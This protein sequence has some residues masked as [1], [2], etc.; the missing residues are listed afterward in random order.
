MPQ[1][2]DVFCWNAKNSARGF[3]FGFADTRQTLRSH[4]LIVAA[5]I[6]VSV[7]DHDDLVLIFCQKRHGS[8][9]GKSVIVR[10][11]CK[12]QDGLVGIVLEPV[13]GA[14]IQR[15]EE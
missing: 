14:S 1:P 6:I 15:Q 13:S 11:G 12:N 10:M 3:F 2:K 4:L 5:L 8:A 9:N 7:D